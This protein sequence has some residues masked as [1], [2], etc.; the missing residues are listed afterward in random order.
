METPTIW[1][2]DA[3]NLDNIKAIA[4]DA[5]VSKEKTM[6]NEKRVEAIVKGMLQ[7]SH[8]RSGE[9]KLT[10]INALADEYL[11]LSYHGLRTKENSFIADFKTDFDETLPKVNVI[12]QD[13]GRVLLNLLNNAFYVVSKKAKEGI[14]GYKPEVVV[15][16]KKHK[17]SIEITEKDN[18]PGIPAEIKDKRAM[19]RDLDWVWVII[20]LPRGMG[21]Q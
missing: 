9:K 13:I 15:C 12:P 1:G 11:R 6:H 19:E 7:H 17:E 8:S 3:G 5:I 16:T 21:G 4:K 2:I 14:D 20:L 10:N 18:G